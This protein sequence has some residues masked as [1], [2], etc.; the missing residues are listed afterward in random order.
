MIGPAPGAPEAATS[1]PA[2]RG[3]VVRLATE[4]VGR[5]LAFGATVILARGLGPA[6]Y[7]TFAVL[8]GVA[9]V[10]AEGADLGLAGTATRTLTERSWR[11][12]D[13][14]R[15]K[16]ALS[17]VVI[18]TAAAVLAGG[19]RPLRALA[20]LVLGV[21]AVSWV[22]AIGIALRCARRPG[23]EAVVVIAAR[24]GLLLAIVAA[25]RAGAG[26]EGYA[27]AT[28]LAPLPALAVA[29][30]LVERA[31]RD[32]PAP[33]RSPQA[34]CHEALP[35]GLATALSLIAF[36]VELWLLLPL[37]GSAEAGLFAGALRAFDGLRLIPGAIAQ[38]ALPYMVLEAGAAR[39]GARHGTVRT[40][41]LLGVPAAIA[42]FALAPELVLLLLGDAFVGAA[43]PAR[44][45][46]LAVVPAFLN[47][48]LLQD[49]LAAG[50]P[51]EM[52]RLMGLRLCASLCLGALAIPALGAPGA[53]LACTVA[54]G[55]VL[56]RGL[57]AARGSGLAEP[58]WAA[59]G[60]SARATLPLLALLAL[61][62][63]PAALGLGLAA[64]A[65]L[66]ARWRS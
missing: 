2:T 55:L 49:V 14:V 38:G 10:V 15:A 56:W 64:Y 59:L 12:R 33:A 60:D 66:A 52:P 35:V 18:G 57:H 61:R 4:F 30:L 39:G 11:L 46:A 58:L 26:F 25:A 29:S 62:P 43:L 47:A 54:E 1:D 44:L 19:P 37:R 21:V 7:G 27:L 8:W 22:E 40:I 53:A 63:G 3:S 28:A 45:L 13:L 34:L 41:V 5:G 48:F 42:L 23:A 31:Y 24:G 50:H 6:S 65:G 17:A 16:L 32:D 51:H 9:W 20:V 36:R